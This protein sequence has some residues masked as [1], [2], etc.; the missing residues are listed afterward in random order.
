ML[1]A[2][3]LKNIEDLITSF[4]KESEF[5]AGLILPPNVK[6][7]ALRYEF[8]IVLI[9]ESLDDVSKKW[10]LFIDQITKKIKDYLLKYDSGLAIHI[11]AL[12][13]LRIEK[14][15]KPIVILHYILTFKDAY[16]NVIYY[17]APEVLY[18]MKKRAS[19][20]LNR[21]IVNSIVNNIIREEKFISSEESDL[22]KKII[23]RNMRKIRPDI[24]KIFG[25]YLYYTYTREYL[26][27]LLNLIN[28]GKKI[29]FRGVWIFSRSISNIDQICQII[30]N[31]K[32]LISFYKELNPK[33]FKGA[34]KLIEILQ[35]PHI[36]A[37][38]ES[39]K[40]IMLMLLEIA[41]TILSCESVLKFS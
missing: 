7:D 29:L 25:I 12:T 14:Y 36:Y 19:F 22:L 5:E 34:K 10:F 35:N 21:S 20:I 3:I 15:G 1:Y 33:L 39:F 6:D 32:N 40:E 13:N 27:G 23:W 18:C 28:V 31:R 4:L 8:D 26:E 11:R 38:K 41:Y 16:E 30:N 9:V 2:D 24:Q 17:L 37:D